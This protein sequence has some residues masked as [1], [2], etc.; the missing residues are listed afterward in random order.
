MGQA[1]GQVLSFGIGVALSPL[2]IIAIVL[3]LATPQGRVNG[4]AFLTGWIVGLAAV[5]TIV[6]VISG[7]ASAS[8]HGAP[9]TWVS[10]LKIALGLVLVALAV[11]QYRGRPRGDTEPELAAWMKAIDTFTPVKS[12]GMAMLLSGVNPKNLLLTV[13]C[14]AAIAQTGVSTVDQAV[15]LAV[16]VALGT[17]GVGALVA[18]YFGMGARATKILGALHQWMARENS[19]I[20]AVLCL[21][22]GAKLIGDAITALSG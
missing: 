9:A 14:A 21:I 11:K 7:S 1:I 12:A 15:A 20:I 3:M 13:G 4:P 5:G 19:T 8:S 17:L 2:P 10:I 18:I 16:F 6:L 22:I